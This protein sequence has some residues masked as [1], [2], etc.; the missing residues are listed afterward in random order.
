MAAVITFTDQRMLNDTY[1]LVNG[2]EALIIDPSFSPKEVLAYIAKKKLKVLAILLT[3]GHYDH[4]AGLKELG[5]ELDCPY[6]ISGKDEGFL[7]DRKYSFAISLPEKKPLIYPED[8]LVIGG[9]KLDIFAA[10]GHTP[11][12]VVI[13]WNNNMFTGDFVFCGDIGRTDLPGSDPKAM[14]ESLAAFSGLSGDYLIYPGHEESST[15][16]KEKQN[17]PYLNR[18]SRYS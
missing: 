9:F 17:N 7:Y 10:P 14:A 16:A 2:S 1:L 8:Q 3:H 13:I 11:G 15:L 6:Y 5:K 18:H 4:F 12:S